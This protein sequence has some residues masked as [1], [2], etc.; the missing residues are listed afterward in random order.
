MVSIADAPSLKRS[1]QGSIEF[2]REVRRACD[3]L[4]TH[5]QAK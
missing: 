1:Q 2:D 4:D 3:D 5:N